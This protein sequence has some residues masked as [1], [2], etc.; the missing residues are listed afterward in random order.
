MR[1]NEE[2]HVKKKIAWINGR[3]DG[4]VLEAKFS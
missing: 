1:G 2:F 4:Y 3:A